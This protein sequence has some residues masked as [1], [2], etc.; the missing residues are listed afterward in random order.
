MSPKELYQCLFSVQ[1]QYLMSG[2]TPVRFLLGPDAVK[3]LFDYNKEFFPD[4]P[5]EPEKFCGMPFGR[6]KTDGVACICKP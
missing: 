1:N 2:I 4:L 5:P 3:A 6:M